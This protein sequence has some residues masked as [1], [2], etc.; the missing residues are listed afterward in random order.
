M[1]CESLDDKFLFITIKTTSAHIVIEVSKKNA[2][3]INLLLLLFS[4][5]HSGILTIST[6]LLPY[7]SLK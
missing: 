3:L 7:S 5:N 4:D 6:A 1:T 2:L